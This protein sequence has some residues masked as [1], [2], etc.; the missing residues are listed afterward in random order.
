MDLVIHTLHG[1]DSDFK[2]IAAAI[3]AR[4]NP[5]TFDELYDKLVSYDDYLQRTATLSHSPLAHSTARQPRGSPGGRQS[6][7]SNPHP[8]SV[9]GPQPT[10]SRSMP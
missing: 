10:A 6:P 9:L 8:A 5:P 3:R 2:E 1:I 7:L 4:D